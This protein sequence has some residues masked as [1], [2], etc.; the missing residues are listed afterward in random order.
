[1]RKKLLLHDRHLI[2]LLLVHGLRQLTSSFWQLLPKLH[3]LV[4]IIITTEESFILL[5]SMVF[6][7]VR[8]L[9][10]SI[11]LV[12]CGVTIHFDHTFAS[13]TV[14]QRQHPTLWG[15]KMVV[16]KMEELTL[17]S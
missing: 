1:M 15:F 5:Q 3:V 7:L 2:N 4:I 16:S 17:E 8:D 10:I 11:F 14:C 9:I 6:Q 12:A 13:S